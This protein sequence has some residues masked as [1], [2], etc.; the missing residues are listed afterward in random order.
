MSYVLPKGHEIDIWV[1][2]QPL[3]RGGM[4][5]VYRCYNRSAKR[6][7]AAIKVLDLNLTTNASIRARF[8]REAEILFSLDHPHIV[9]VRNIRIDS[10]LPYLEMEFIEGESLET[11][12]ESGALPLQE[13]LLIGQQIASSLS[14]LHE[15]GI[16]HRDIKPSNILVQPDKNAKLVDFGIATE[17]DRTTLSEGG[18][19]FGS[20]AFVPPEWVRPGELDAVKWDIYALGVCLFEA[21]TGTMAFDIPTQGSPWQRFYQVIV[22]KQNHS[23][24]DPGPAFPEHVRN[25]IREMTHPDPTK[26]LQTAQ[27]AWQ[28][29][30]ALVG[31]EPPQ[32]ESIT[33]MPEE[34]PK[35]RR[36]PYLVGGLGLAGLL[37]AGFLINQKSATRSVQ[38]EI[39]GPTD[40]PVMLSLSGKEPTNVKGSTFV[41]KKIKPGSY[42]LQ[43]TLGKNCEQYPATC[44]TLETTL[45]VESGLGPVLLPWAISAPE[46]RE[47]QL[48]IT[49][50]LKP[51][52]FKVNEAP[53]PENA[54]FL[55]GIYPIQVGAGQCS[56][57][58]D[59]LRCSYYTGTLEIPWGEGFFQ[60]ELPLKAPILQAPSPTPSPS[61][62]PAPIRPP[63]SNAQLASWLINHPE[64]QR[65]QAIAE[66]R[67][68]SK[69]LNGWTGATPPEGKSSLVATNINW[70]LAAAY[71]KKRGGLADVYAAPLQW[72][73]SSVWAWHELRQSNNT[74][75]WRRKDDTAGFSLNPK[76]TKAA[77][78]FRCSR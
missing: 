53:V 57:P 49:G 11:K 36:W 23:P 37:L 13:V 10:S 20:V 6:I 61:A 33:L 2:E 77:A 4:G 74:P 56:E 69:F 58:L 15:R 78:G 62:T 73:E 70:D 54:A 35:K 19:V 50:G 46:P 40:L 76:E 28:R 12:L 52:F 44:G 29:L 75:A 68:D 22:A 16:R 39:Q 18:Q 34:V 59:P 21:M 38:I 63:V 45:E 51:D 24:L 31:N 14:Y 17:S 47:L 1:I 55:P 64:W 32:R 27:E 30:K 26:R 72:S 43:A 9:K 3:G 42:I 5:S 66:G 65:E 67:A 71:C 8:V 60:T 25:L 7:L 48:S 41:F